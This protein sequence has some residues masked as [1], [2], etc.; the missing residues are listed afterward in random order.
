MK[1]TTPSP[2]VPAPDAAGSLPFPFARFRHLRFGPGGRPAACLHCHAPR[3]QRWGR[4]SGRQRYRCTACHRTFS[5]FTG[6][7]LAHLE[8]VD[9]WPAFGR[10]MLASV[11]VRRAAAAIGVHPATAFRW[12]HRLLGAMDATDA[13]LL[14][15]SVAIHETWFPFSEKGKRDLDRPPRRRSVFGR[16]DIPRAWLYLAADDDGRRASGVVGPKRPEVGDLIA[17]LDERVEPEAE[18]TSEFG[19]LGA[20]GL[21]AERTGRSYRRLRRGDP[22]FEAVHGSTLALRR[23]IRRFHGVATRYLQNYV[24]WHRFLELAAKL[25]GGGEVP[26]L[27]RREAGSRVVGLAAGPTGRAAES[28]GG[29]CVAPRHWLLPG[30]FP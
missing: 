22:D 11:P 30:F 5:D 12:R 26:S 3:P 23:W 17:A 14:V 18:I 16:L 4:F 1:T 24:A 10:C 20:A 25:E 28:R 6:T 13:A 27:R 8:R 2:R 7:P 19:P 29:W 15:T 9:R 21:M